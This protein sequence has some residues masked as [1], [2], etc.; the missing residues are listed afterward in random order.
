MGQLAVVC[1]RSMNDTLNDG[2]LIFMEKIT[3]RFGE[4]D[5]YDIIIFDSNLNQRDFIKR[6]IGLPGETVR[7]DKSGNIYINEQLIEENYGKEIMI[8][9]GIAEEGVTLGEK[10]Y[11]VLGDN[12]NNSEDSRFVEL[13]PINYYQIKGK[14][15]FSII[16]FG[17]IE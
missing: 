2:D 15:C 7:I 17:K 1:G 10:E 14:V 9:P 16:P 11:F 13:G 5:R 3:Q 6:I 4:L 8:Y 12:R